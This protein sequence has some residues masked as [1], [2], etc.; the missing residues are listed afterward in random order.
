MRLRIFLLLF[1]F[2][3]VSAAQRNT[4][5][6]ISYFDTDSFWNALV[7]VPTLAAH[8]DCRTAPAVVVVSNRKPEPGQIRFMSQDRDGDSLHYFFITT[9]QGQW[10]LSG[11]PDLRRAVTLMRCEPHRRNRD[12]VVYTEGMGKLFTSDINRAFSM[13][14]QYDL[15]VLLL[16]YPSIHK[17]LSSLKNFKFARRNAQLAGSDFLPVL[18]SMLRFREA[19]I[20]GEGRLTLFYHSLGNQAL[21]MLAKSASLSRINNK[22]WVDNLI[23]NAPCVPRRGA[24]RW[25]SRIAF[26]K[27]LYVFYNSHDATLKWARLAS[28]HGIL[29]ERPVPPLCKRA[30]YVNFH[31]LCGGGHSNFLSLRGRQPAMPEAVDYYRVVL[32]GKVPNPKEFTNLKPSRFHRIGFDI[33]PQF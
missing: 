15:N 32:H 11:V 5:Q 26:A 10:H 27:H 2:P 4:P 8:E 7:R 19:G 9:E 28:F 18:D 23:L 20:L 31:L 33:W 3:L 17:G 1:L 12:W 6:Y 29:G 25:M 14:R 30:Q 13:A 21:R 24:T 16:D 22:L